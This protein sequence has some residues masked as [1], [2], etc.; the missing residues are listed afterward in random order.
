ME[1]RGLG[2]GDREEDRER[3]WADAGRW[4][5]TVGGGG[6]VGLDSD[7]GVEEVVD[8]LVAD[9]DGG[10]GGDLEGGGGRRFVTGEGESE[11]IM[12]EE[13]RTGVRV[14]V[15]VIGGKGEVEEG[16]DLG[17]EGDAVEGRGVC[18]CVVREREDAEEGRGMRE[19]GVVGIDKE[20]GVE[21][22]AGDENDARV[23]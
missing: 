11:A 6:R 4:G 22:V 16:V 8:T 19:E 3:E 7:A 2:K 21:G 10:G 9:A 1:L 15:I 23:D 12:E 18:G 20:D 5:V 17:V 14:D 13:G